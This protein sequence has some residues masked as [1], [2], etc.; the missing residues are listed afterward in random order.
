MKTPVLLL[1]GTSDRAVMTCIRSFKKHGIP[2]YLV[3]PNNKISL[4]SFSRY[5]KNILNKKYHSYQ[6]LSQFKQSLK[7]ATKGLPELILFPIGENQTRFLLKEKEWLFS[8]GIILPVSEYTVFI[9]LSDKLSFTKLSEKYGLCVPKQVSY[10]PKSTKLPIVAKPK[11]N[12]DNNLIKKVPYLIFNQKQFE[13]FKNNEDPNSFFYQE[14]VFGSTYYYCALYKQ[15]ILIANF[16]HLTCVQ[17][18]NGGSVVKAIPG[19]IDRQ[20]M[21]K[22]DKILFDKNWSGPIMVELKFQNGNY[23][24]IEANARLWGPLQLPYDNGV[25]FPYLLYKQC[26]QEES[27]S[28][29]FTAANSAYSIGYLWRGGYFLEFTKGVSF[30]RKQSSSMYRDAS[31]SNN[32]TFKDVWLRSDSFELYFLELVNTLVFRPVYLLSKKILRYIIAHLRTLSL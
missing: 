12:I 16:V 6:N 2:F 17:Q 4:W 20:T 27:E 23:Y 32:F 8:I 28:V 19:E 21:L 31:A 15:G 7:D 14:Y 5:R 9:A 10:A 11:K 22:I 3:L 24:V 26:K 29:I 25:D 30:L 18:S 13:H 1:A